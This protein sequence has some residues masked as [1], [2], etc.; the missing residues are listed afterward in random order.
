MTAT[1]RNRRI[2]WT[3]GGAALILCGMLQF[4]GL[5]FGADGHAVATVT[6]NVLYLAAVL[7]FAFGIA[8]GASVVDRRPLGVVSLAI[9]AVWP[10]GS[11]IVFALTPAPTAAPTPATMGGSIAFNYATILV[12]LAAGLIACVQIG[13]VAVVPRPWQW[14]PLAVLALQTTVAVITQVLIMTPAGQAAIDVIF[15]FGSLGVVPGTLGLGI[16]ALVLAFA[17]P[18]I[19]ERSADSGETAVSSSIPER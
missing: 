4:S 14:A 12:T 7:M 15:A 2:T 1:E 3:A 18:R 6:A 10:V 13:R 5:S 8:R 19:S 16:L 17:Q 11:E 9:I